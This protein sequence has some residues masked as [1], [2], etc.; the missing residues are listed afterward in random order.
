RIKVRALPQQEGVACAISD[1][2]HADLA[3]LEK[4]TV[5]GWGVFVAERALATIAAIAAEAVEPV[6]P[7]I[8][9]G[10]SILKHGRG[11][12]VR[13]ANA[14]LENLG[15]GGISPADE[16]VGV[17]CAIPSPQEVLLVHEGEHL[18]P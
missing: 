17:D 16:I 4:D 18:D 9:R 13:W 8:W 10:E 7:V 15:G 12:Q 14:D 2:Q 11:Q 5:Q 1:L 3:A 6:R